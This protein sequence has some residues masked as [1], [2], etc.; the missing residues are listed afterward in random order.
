MLGSQQNSPEKCRKFF[1]DLAPPDAG[2]RPKAAACLDLLQ[3]RTN[4]GTY[5]AVGA[6]HLGDD[7]CENV[8]TL[9]PTP[10]RNVGERC[11][12]DSDC[13]VQPGARGDCYDHGDGQPRCIERKP[14]GVGDGPCRTTIV[15][16]YYSAW[17]TGD[18]W[19]DGPG[20]S[21]FECDEMAGTFCEEAT[22]T[23]VPVFA[24]GEP[25]TGG[26]T[27]EGLSRCAVA[28]GESMARCHPRV[29]LGEACDHDSRICVEGAGCSRGVCVALQVVNT[30]CDD[31]AQC[32]SYF[33]QNHLCAPMLHQL[34]LP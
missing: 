22:H 6:R 5:C 26:E 13:I 16:G 14:G 24:V 28:P 21:Y 11:Q 34:C 32:G 7:P 20:G 8:F 18:S 23:C 25:C 4:D 1:D 30:P 10:T 31:D 27:C 19:K 9:Y 33:C 17:G 2:E 29:E 15:P 3:S 12:R